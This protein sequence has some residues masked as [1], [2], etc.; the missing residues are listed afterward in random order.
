MTTIG[1]ALYGGKWGYDRWEG[2][3]VDD[4]MHGEGIMYMVDGGG[5]AL[6][7]VFEHGELAGEPPC[8]FEYE[9][10]I[11]FRRLGASTTDATMRS[12]LERFG[13]LDY[14]YIARGPDGASQARQ[15]VLPR[16]IPPSSQ[17]LRESAFWCLGARMWLLTSPGA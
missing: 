12:L 8:N 2:R 9:K 15:P 17:Y 14:C 6:P 11:F 10:S 1:A 5:E 4:L 16:P 13:P 7:W 3:F